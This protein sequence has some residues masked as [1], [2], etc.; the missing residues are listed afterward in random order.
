MAW[1]TPKTWTSE[2]LTSN[3]MNTYLSDNTQY[4]YDEV[5]YSPAVY[6]YS[7]T[8]GDY[9]TTSA[10]F[11]DIDASNM[12]ATITTDGGD[13]L[14]TFAGTL[15]RSGGSASGVNLGFDYDGTDYVILRPLVSTTYGIGVNASFSVILDNVTAG[16]HTFRM[17]WS[18]DAT[19]ATAYILASSGKSAHF[20][21]RELK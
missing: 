16:S 15:T 17:Q 11:V 21:V 18:I 3:D 20:G 8:T 9:S 2:V 12:V 7:R 4:L 5:T 6:T 1:T 10:T 19:G 14:I 13:V